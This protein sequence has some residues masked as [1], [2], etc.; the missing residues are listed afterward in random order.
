MIMPNLKDKIKEL[1]SRKEVEKITRVEKCKNGYKIY[2][3]ITT[4]YAQS[5]QLQYLNR[6]YE[7]S[8]NLMLAEDR[9]MEY[10]D[11]D[12]IEINDL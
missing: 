5:Q 10:A 7:Y 2:F 1:Q 3:K 11:T 8:F 4:D 12:C 9:C 6:I